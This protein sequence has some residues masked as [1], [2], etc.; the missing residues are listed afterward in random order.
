M[1]I[2]RY[3]L[4][5]TPIGVAAALALAQPSL[6]AM[7]GEE[8]AEAPGG[9]HG[10]SHGGWRRPHFGERRSF[11][12]HDRT[13]WRGGHWAHERHGGR[14][15]WWWVAGDDWFFYPDPVYPYPD[16]DV[17]PQQDATPDQDPVGLVEP[18]DPAA[19]EPRPIASSASLNTHWKPTVDRATSPSRS[20]TIGGVAPHVGLLVAMAL[21]VT[22][23]VM[24]PTTIAFVLPRMTQEYGLKSPL[25]PAGTFSVAYFPLVAMT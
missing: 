5:A 19:A 3:L 21:G 1:K 12:D 9:W 16:P 13:L 4:L 10:D 11:D 8:R 6:A 25:N 23:D 22:V 20:Q 18:T 17:M 7:H 2:A 24:K 15:G 14:F